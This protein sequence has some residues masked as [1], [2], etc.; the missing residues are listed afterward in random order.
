MDAIFLDIDEY[1]PEDLYDPNDKF[2]INE[3]KLRE[4]LSERLAVLNKII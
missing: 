2:N 3:D 1:N 4:R